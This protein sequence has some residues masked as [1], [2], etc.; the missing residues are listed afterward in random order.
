MTGRSRVLGLGPGQVGWHVVRG[1]KAATFINQ[2]GNSLSFERL[3]LV[4]SG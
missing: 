3:E 4:L 1:V 2:T